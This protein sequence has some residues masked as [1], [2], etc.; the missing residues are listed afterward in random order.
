MICR[1]RQA[2]TTA[3][4]SGGGQV[5]GAARWRAGEPERCAVG[6]GDDLR[7]HPVLAVFHRVVR[8]V[9]AHPV[10]RDQRAVDDDVIALIETGERFVEARRPAGQDVQGLV[11][12]PPGGGLGYPEICSELRERLVLPQVHQ[13][14]QRLLEAAE[15]AP[16]GV[17]GLGMLV[18]QPG[19]M[20]DELMSDVERGRTRKPSGPLRS[21]V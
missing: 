9:R 14:E 8:L 4:G 2:W 10:D 11:Y 1:V 19:D 13:R 3:V 16:A 20:L 7:V 5:V 12:V 6:T 15:L 21:P 17:A 18:Q